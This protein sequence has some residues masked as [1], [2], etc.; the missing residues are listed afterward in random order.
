MLKFRPTS[1]RPTTCGPTLWANYVYRAVISWYL[2]E[3]LWHETTHA[4]S[5][6]TI[7][8]LKRL[9]LSEDLRVMNEIGSCSH[10]S[11]IHTI[12]LWQ[13]WERCGMCWWWEKIVILIPI[14]RWYVGTQYLTGC[15]CFVR[16]IWFH[17]VLSIIDGMSR[18]LARLARVHRSCY[19]YTCWD[20]EMGRER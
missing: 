11:Y 5:W 2:V 8:N 20:T 6:S 7:W 15:I 9:R 16:E 4:S 13:E 17:T 1:F 18:W 10:P 12:N 14:E 19:R 3:W